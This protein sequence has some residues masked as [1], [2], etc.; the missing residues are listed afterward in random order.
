MSIDQVSVAIDNGVERILECA[1]FFCQY[2]SKDVDVKDHLESLEFLLQECVE[3]RRDYENSTEAKRNMENVIKKKLENEEEDIEVERLYK[4]L[5]KDVIDA[6]KEI[7]IENTDVMK[8]FHKILKDEG[9]GES[10][11]QGEGDS[12]DE[13]LSQFAEI[14]VK[15]PFTRAIMKNPVR[16]LKCGHIYEKNS[17]IELLKQNADTKCPTVGCLNRDAIQERDLVP[18]KETERALK[19]HR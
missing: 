5:K 13:I 12:D 18:D 8:R 2:G 17:V 15:D 3:S 9:Q 10:E 14:N 4:T 1:K 19:R 6:K 16:N 7:P 11:G